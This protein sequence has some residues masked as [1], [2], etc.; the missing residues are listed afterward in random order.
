MDKG[1]C[2]RRV[3][4]LDVKIIKIKK[5]VNVN[6]LTPFFCNQLNVKLN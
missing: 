3:S 4:N 2:K 5:G 6:S 1:K